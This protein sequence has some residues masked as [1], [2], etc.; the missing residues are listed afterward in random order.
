MLWNV[1]AE[2]LQAPCV[3]GLLRLTGTWN[4]T[5]PLFHASRPYNVAQRIALWGS[6]C[7]STLPIQPFHV[8]WIDII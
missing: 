7:C 3:I 1:L 6:L 4:G 5:S 8:Y 2:L